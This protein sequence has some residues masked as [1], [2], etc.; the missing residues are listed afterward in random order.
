MSKAPASRFAPQVTV[1]IP[2][3]NG[4][5]HLAAAIDSILGQSFGDFELLIIDDGSTDASAALA[6]GYDDPRIRLESNARNLGVVATLNRG[7]AMARGDF[8]ARM[9]ADDIALPVRLE[10]QLAFLASHPS[11]VACGTWMSAF[12]AGTAATWQAPCEHAEIMARLLFE[13]CL[14]HP[15]VMLRTAVLR[16]YGVSYDGE[17]RHAEDYELW[18]RLAAY[19]QLA[20]LGE[21]LLNYRLHDGNIGV[22]HRGEQLET[23]GR[24]RSGLLRRMGLKP[25]PR[26]LALHEA[27]CL[28]EEV[29]LATLAAAG[30]WIVD[31]VKACRTVEWV[32]EDALRREASDR[33]S[34][35][36]RGS[37]RHGLE[38]YRLFRALTHDLG[39]E[40]AFI[41]RLVLICRCLM[42]AGG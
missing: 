41:A 24:V 26:E 18:T 2:V 11:V 33:F 34:L 3:Y 27:L 10:R 32:A 15:T 37:S 40:P 14:F 28:G 20:N 19:G 39:A 30:H 6:A 13:S 9:D 25:G 17:Y 21:V 31:L 1:L 16:T 8:I 7:L 12:G 29:D 22:A 5:R 4:E 36:C 42:R 38:T 23:A 35:L